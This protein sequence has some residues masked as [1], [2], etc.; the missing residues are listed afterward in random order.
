MMSYFGHKKGKEPAVKVEDQPDD[1]EGPVL[2][3]EDEAFL[4]RIATEG[5]P[6]PLPERPRP[7]DLPTAGES[8]GNNAQLVLLKDAQDVPLPNAPDTPAEEIASAIESEAPQMSKEKHK[9]KKKPA[10]WSFLRRDSRDGKRKAQ[11]E[12]ATGLMGVAEGLKSVEAQPNEG[13]A[14]SDP[15]AKKEE[16]EMTAIMD[17]LNLA[18]VDNRVFSISKESKDLLQKHASTR[19]VCCEFLLTHVLGSLLFLKIS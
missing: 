7:Q 16:A 12:T 2:S 17:D 13:H 8:E 3:E 6:P 4:H 5:T 18:A 14:V 11:A 9:E 10:R 1:V 15:E 19:L